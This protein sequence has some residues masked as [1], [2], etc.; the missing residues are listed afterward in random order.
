MEYH[1]INRSYDGA[2][3]SSKCLWCCVSDVLWIC[4]V[5]IVVVCMCLFSV[6]VIWC[7]MVLI[8]ARNGLQEHMEKDQLNSR[9]SQVSK[10]T[11]ITINS[12]QQEATSDLCGLSVSYVCFYCASF[13]LY[14]FVYS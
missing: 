7:C 8:I 12:D 10:Y 4:V 9:C 6:M 14:C 3:D 1:T 11:N 13:V 5:I 2:I